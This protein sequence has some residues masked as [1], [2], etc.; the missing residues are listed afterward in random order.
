MFLSHPRVF[1]DGAALEL[2]MS[3][4]FTHAIDFQREMRGKFAVEVNLEINSFEH[5]L[6][7]VLSV[8]RAVYLYCEV[9]FFLGNN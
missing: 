5:I 6:L 8:I 1:G 7:T 3:Q 9:W 2:K 4:P